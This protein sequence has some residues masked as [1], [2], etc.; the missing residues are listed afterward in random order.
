MF[1]L[2]AHIFDA[3]PVA[4]ASIKKSPLRERGSEKEM[5]KE[6]EREREKSSS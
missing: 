4:V 3:Y 6:K 1:S 2:S 5:E